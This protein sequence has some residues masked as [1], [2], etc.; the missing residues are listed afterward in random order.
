MNKKLRALLE[1]KNKLIADAR[2]LDKVAEAAGRDFNDDEREQSKGLLAQLE[3]LNGDIERER[4]L[5]AA[6]REAAGLSFEGNGSIS[7][8]EPEVLKDPKRGFK[9]L[10][11]FAASVRS[12]NDQRLIVLNAAAPSTYGNESVGADGGYLVPPE[13]SKQ[14]FQHSLEEE[15]ILSMTDENPISGNSMVFPKDETTPWGSD[16]I[17]AYWESEAAAAT[18]TKPKLGV[19]QQ[20]LHKLFGLVP[21]TD[22]LLADVATL[23]SYLVSKTGESIRWKS[24]DAFINGTGAGMPLG[25]LLSSALVSVAKE[26]GQ[27]ADTLVVQNIAKMFARMPAG[28]LGRSV[29]M[30]NNDV[31]PQLI[32]MVLNN[33]PI[34]TPPGGLPNAPAGL[35]LG[36]PIKITQH[37]K[38]L[39]DQGDV[40]FVD[41]KMYRTITKRGGI[42]TATS[43]HLYF[44]AGAMAFRA[45]FRVD[46]QPAISSAISP[47]NGSNSLSPFVVLDERA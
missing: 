13:F 38:T 37:A 22:E 1:R 47:A 35:L 2:A 23:D 18:A 25:I 5:I 14:V 34:Y 12:G 32:T 46:G 41:W 27:S 10:G 26:S 39:G 9:S 17:R 15:S 3:A 42:E 36:R 16:G 19:M 31:L 29:W 21:V 4:T 43:M 30:I 44:D 28:S 11:D 8:M 7:G 33:Y 6:E 20:R 45:T 40:Q 24:D